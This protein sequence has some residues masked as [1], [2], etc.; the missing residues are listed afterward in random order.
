MG[1]DAITHFIV[2]LR[3]VEPSGRH[4]LQNLGGHAL[5][6]Q[7][8]LVSCPLYDVSQNMQSRDGNCA[9][10]SLHRSYC[11]K[12]PCLDHLMEARAGGLALWV[13]GLQIS[14]NISRRLL[15]SL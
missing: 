9:F 7:D 1:K 3:S 11:S 2:F 6:V 5:F 15:L 4:A 13:L 10:G 12:A 14:C 8:L